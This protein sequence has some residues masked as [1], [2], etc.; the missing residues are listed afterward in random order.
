VRWRFP[1]PNDVPE[2]ERR[3]ALQLAMDRWWQQFGKAVP[4]L[5]ATF[6]HQ[7]EFDVAEFMEQHLGPVD[8]RLMWEYG[9]PFR[10][11]EHRLVITPESDRQL[12]PLLGVLLSRAP[13][14][15]GWEFYPYRLPES[16]SEAI[17]TVEARTEVEISSFRVRATRGE[18]NFVDLK[19]SF[20]P[21]TE[22]EDMHYVAF[23]ASEALLGEEVVE[24]WI[25]DIGIEERA[26]PAAALD[27]EDP[28]SLPV[29]V[30]AVLA[31]IE[32]SLPA[33][34]QSSTEMG[35]VYELEPEAGEDY[36]ERLDLIVGTTHGLPELWQAAH[37]DFAFSS[38]RFSKVGETFCYVK[39]DGVDDVNHGDVEA[40]AKIEEALDALLRPSGLGSVI[41][42]GTGRRYSYIDLAL[43]HLDHGL[44]E[45]QAALQ[46]AAVPERSW[47]LFFDAHLADEWIG[48]YESTP[49][50]PQSE[51]DDDDDEPEPN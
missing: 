25:G 29:R 40:R 8:S 41:G 7:A 31:E 19:W 36:P 15:P 30:Q 33:D 42:G 17:A 2:T 45:V 22:A 4:Q 14:L 5:L 48:I 49:P 47:L 20:P 39:M 10:G 28:E 11:G 26:E 12:R 32:Q 13:A 51:P 50:P 24:T 23:V 27:A 16:W 44:S 9:P 37:S 21:G 46:R 3:M 43:R 18:F 35:F 6:S 34:A 38:R 1:D